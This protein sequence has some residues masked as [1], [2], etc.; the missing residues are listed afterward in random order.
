MLSCQAKHEQTGRRDVATDDE[1]L[2]LSQY[3][4][5]GDAEVQRL[6]FD[7]WDRPIGPLAQLGLDASMLQSLKRS[8]LDTYYTPVEIV[9][10]VW[11]VALRLLG[12][13]EA[14]YVLEPACG[15]GV[16]L[17]RSPEQ[18]QRRN[19]VGVEVDDVAYNIAWL[20]HDDIRIAAASFESVAQKLPLFDLVIGNAPFG[21]VKVSDE[22]VPAF[23]RRTLH[24]YF[25]CR[26]V[27]SLRRGGYAILL[28]STGTLDKQRSDVRK[29]LSM[30]AELLFALR[31]PTKTFIGT[32]A[33]AD[34]LVLRRCDVDVLKPS[35]DFLEVSRLGSDDGAARS[36]LWQPII[37]DDLQLASLDVN[38]YYRLHPE[39]VVGDWGAR[40][41]RYGRFEAV[42]EF[43][44]TRV[45]LFAAVKQHIEAMA[46]ALPAPTET[47]KRLSDAV[48]VSAPTTVLS[49]LERSAKRVLEAL[50]RLLAAQQRGDFAAEQRLLGVVYDD[51]VRRWGRVRD[52]AAK[53]I[54]DAELLRAWPLLRS[55]ETKD[56]EKAALFTR[57]VVVET[58]VTQCHDVIDA[59]YR[60][61][62]SRG[63]IDVEA[64]AR[65]LCET[66]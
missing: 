13:S 15:T 3:S 11:S 64:I 50:R 31:L 45:A 21:D 66:S 32:D 17:G 51:F 30:H 33:D 4:G 38:D 49:P 53:S 25:V 55:L 52:V 24:D 22:T 2:V 7:S 26:S 65:L 61:L 37:D 48:S 54:A 60:V 44:G 41:T 8:T 16:F 5:F 18:W 9:D 40:R 10:A 59:M 23:C 43:S 46:A 63:V 47:P 14:P 39:H 42:V 1:K 62:D 19:F 12:S 35:G 34:L 56:G 27:L 58:T 36:P 28:T 57:R 6:A 20:L 29:W